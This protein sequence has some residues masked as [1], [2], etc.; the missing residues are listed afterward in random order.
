MAINKKSLNKKLFS[1]EIM[2]HILGSVSDFL[3]HLPFLPMVH[4]HVTN[5]L[6][7]PRY[8]YTECLLGWANGLPCVQVSCEYV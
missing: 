1:D 8:D 2:T 7:T 4:V 6:S 3:P 5:Y